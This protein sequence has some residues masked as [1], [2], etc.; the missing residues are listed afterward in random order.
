MVPSPDR[1]AW[2]GVSKNVTANCSMGGTAPSPVELGGLE[3]LIGASWLLKMDNI[4]CS[5][6]VLCRQYREF[7]AHIEQQVFTFVYALRTCLAGM[8]LILSK[9]SSH[10][11]TPI[12]GE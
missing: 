9:R 1:T 2:Q 3:L 11:E 12:A 4:D 5:T 7:V 8:L 6:D 10:S